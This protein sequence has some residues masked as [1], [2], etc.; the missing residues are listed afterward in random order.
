M[1][2][3]ENFPT[4]GATFQFRSSGGINVA[5]IWDPLYRSGNKR[6]VGVEA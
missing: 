3:N 2:R 5:V 1:L 6:G 4:F